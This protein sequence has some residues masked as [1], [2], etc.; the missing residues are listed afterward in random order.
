LWS[1]GTGGS[2]GTGN[3]AGTSWA[4]DTGGSYRSGFSDWT[5][6]AC[7]TSGA[8]VAF[9]GGEGSDG[10]LEE[11]D[12]DVCGGGL[13]LDDEEDAVVRLQLQHGL[14]GTAYRLV[15]GGAGVD[16]DLGLGDPICVGV[17][18]RGV[19]GVVADVKTAGVLAVGEEV[20]GGDDVEQAAWP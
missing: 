11:L 16:V 6:G 9:F 10:E 7:R 14:D 4:G 15:G 12:R 1:C 19:V 20:E 2:C 3:T 8:F 18:R 5:S 13:V 17:E